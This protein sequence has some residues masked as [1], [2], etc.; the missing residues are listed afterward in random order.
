MTVETFS[1]PVRISGAG[2][3]CGVGCVGGEG[4]STPGGSLPFTE[5]SHTLP[6]IPCPPPSTVRH[7]SNLVSYTMHRERISS[8]AASISNFATVGTMRKQRRRRETATKR[9]STSSLARRKDA[10]KLHTKLSLVKKPVHFDTEYIFGQDLLFSR[11]R[12]TT[13]GNIA[14]A[15]QVILLT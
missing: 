1:T 10:A 2:R 13:R 12:F 9:K 4:E 7:L 15:E 3:V 6:I 5:Y 14:V 11:L 8:L